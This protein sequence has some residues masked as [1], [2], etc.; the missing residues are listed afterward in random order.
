MTSHKICFDCWGYGASKIGG[1]E[2]VVGG[3]KVTAEVIDAMIF[4][5]IWGIA[6]GQRKTTRQFG[7]REED[8]RRGLIWE[9]TNTF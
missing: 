6:V 9:R 2:E 3:E 4:A 5:F 8:A 1:T 7:R